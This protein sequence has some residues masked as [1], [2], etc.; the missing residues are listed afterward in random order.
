M[1][2]L[3]AVL[4]VQGQTLD[5]CWHAAEQNYPLVSRYDLIRQTADLTIENISK[6]WYPQI[7]ASAQTTLQNRVVELPEALEGLMQAQGVEVKG[8]SKTQYRAGLDLQQLIYDGG[9]IKS[10]KE[11]V[12]RQSDV[13]AYQNEV[14]IYQV[15]RRVSDLYFGI[16]LVDEQIRRTHAVV[17]VLLA[18]EKKL[19]SMYN[20]GTASLYD[21]NVM[22]TERIRT[23]QQA[24]ELEVQ[25]KSLATLLTAF[26]G[27][28]VGTLTRPREV[29]VSLSPA[30]ARPELKL[31]AGQEA[32]ADA[33]ERKLRAER[34]PVVSAFASGYYGYPGYDM[35]HDMF[36]RKWTLN[37]TIGLRISWDL[38]WIWT[39]KNNRKK[40]AL[41]RSMAQNNRET[42]LFNNRLEQLQYADEMQKYKSL[43]A[44]DK[45]IVA[46]RTQMRQAAES[47]LDHGIIA[48]NDLV[49]DITNESDAHTAL[50]L[51]EI[52]YLKSMYDKKLTE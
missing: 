31:F 4:R 27:Q 25:R 52:Q 47:K 9:R 42:F 15:R 3:L 23:E 41:Q 2:L 1:F 20:R 13:E 26:T 49:R 33:N 51:H 36:S 38:G 22:K 30:T 35:Y 8:L 18:N 43:L 48:A 45:E 7:K 40:I 39:D 14:S 24:T 34:R 28:P 29:S 10:G 12:R 44:Y 50:S 16:L 5:E 11:V 6:G 21:L 17:D 32:L 37:G 46:L 19:Q